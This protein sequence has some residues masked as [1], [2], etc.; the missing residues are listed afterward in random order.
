MHADSHCWDLKGIPPQGIHLV[1][2]WQKGRCSRRRRQHYLTFL[3]ML[4]RHANQAWRASISQSKQCLGLTGA[5]RVQECSAGVQKL[6]VEAGFWYG[7]DVYVI[8]WGA[9][10]LFGK[11]ATSMEQWEG[12]PWNLRQPVLYL[13]AVWDFKPPIV[14]L[15]VTLAMWKFLGHCNG[16]TSISSRLP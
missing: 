5:S 1:K 4:T 8:W 13:Q 11:A 2:K 3:Q 7:R 16:C 6:L 15:E 9:Q 10:C 12:K 14:I